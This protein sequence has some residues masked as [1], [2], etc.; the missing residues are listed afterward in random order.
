MDKD[1]AAIAAYKKR[2]EKRMDEYERKENWVTIRGVHVLLDK[3]GN[4]INN[5]KDPEHKLKNL[6]FV[7]AVSSH[8][9]GGKKVTDAPLQRKTHEAKFN[10]AMDKLSGKWGGAVTPESGTKNIANALHN[11]EQGAVVK[12]GSLQALKQGKG[13][14]KIK[15]ESGTMTAK[16]LAARIAKGITASGGFASGFPEV[17]EGT[18]TNIINKGS[19]RITHTAQN[20]LESLYNKYK[21]NKFSRKGLDSMSKSYVS[22][23]PD[24]SELSVGGNTFAKKN[25]SW[26]ITD[27][28]TKHKIADNIMAAVLLNHMSTGYSGGTLKVKL[29]AEVSKGTESKIEKAAEKVIESK[30]KP[31][32]MPAEMPAE[33]PAAPAE[34]PAAKK[35]SASITDITSGTGTDAEKQSALADAIN[36]MPDGTV[37]AYESVNK[38]GMPVVRKGTKMGDKLKFAVKEVPIKYITKSLLKA[39][40]NGKKVGTLDEFPEEAK[41][42][43]SSA[44]PTTTESK[45]AESKPAESKPAESKPAESKP[46]ATIPPP[47]TF[48]TEKMKKAAA[49]KSDPAKYHPDTVAATYKDWKSSGYVTKFDDKQKKITNDWYAKQ[50]DKVKKDFYA[51]TGSA[52]ISINDALRDIA[53]T[54]PGNYMKSRINGMT[55]ALEENKSTEPMYLRRGCSFLSFAGMFGMTKKD[56]D[57]ILKSDDAAEKVKETFLGSVGINNGFTSCG[58]TPG[59][60]FTGKHVDMEIYCPEGTEYIF[61]NPFSAHKS[62]KGSGEYETILQRGTAYR[63]TGIEKTEY[64]RLKVKCEIVAQRMCVDNFGDDASN[65]LAPS[66]KLAKA[67]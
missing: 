28:G 43:E 66:K 63:I 19:Q 56:L 22:S 46:A 47:K 23:L 17:K 16:Q 35:L 32:E 36:N 65:A 62:F 57:D 18:N 5:F 13:V 59:T 1:K 7:D 51:Y 20:A 40:A 33:K 27:G 41:S 67:V 58:S 48:A 14:F 42:S 39:A 4:V 9:E 30:P 3:H 54:D 12:A 53:T 26:S 24:G 61:A 60:G 52:Y 45:P 34:K 29:P 21:S 50:T 25:G 31:A 38:A 11:L 2:R 10:E 44:A 55:K 49:I 8:T 15:G 6:R 37:I 64:G